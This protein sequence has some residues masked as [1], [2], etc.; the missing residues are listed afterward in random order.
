MNDKSKVKQLSRRLEDKDFDDHIRNLNKDRVKKCRE[1]KKAALEDKENST[2]TEVNNE[3]VTPENNQSV[4]MQDVTAPTTSTPVN[5][6]STVFRSPSS[7]P[8]NR[9]SLNFLPQSSTSV[10]PHPVA[11]DSSPS[12]GDTSVRFK[13]PFAKQNGDKQRRET[14]RNKNNT[15]EQLESQMDTLVKEND[16]LEEDNI[17]L[18]LESC[19]Q[20]KTIRNLED[21]KKDKFSWF[22]SMWKFCS[23]DTKREIKAAI[24]AAKDEFPTG[25]IKALRD[26]T[27]INFSNPLTVSNQLRNTG[28]LHQQI[29]DFANM[30]SFEVP[31]KKH[32]KKSI[33][34]MSHFK[35]VLHQQFLMENPEIDCHY[36]TFC[37]HFPDN[38]LKPGVNSHG[39]CLCEDCE[40]FSLK[41]EAMKRAKLVSDINLDQIIRSGR[42]GDIQ[43]EQDFLSVLSELKNSD[44]KDSVIS[45]FKWEDNKQVT[46]G[47]NGVTTTTKKMTR[48]NFQVTVSTLIDK[49]VESFEPLKQ[50]LHRDKVIKNF[51]REVRGEVQNDSSMVC[52]TVDLSENGTLIIPGEVQTAFFG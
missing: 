4:N 35:V 12:A 42:D 37:T 28:D 20:K 14:L 18:V 25:V 36:S 22:K 16:K 24:Q 15:I 6:T 7:T 21:E 33:R 3:S 26:N 31:D 17:S 51:I 34:Y 44:K 1:R 8:I 23:Q 46:H 38:I 45:Y 2:P 13:F 9:I 10:T 11:T 29:V 52:I 30:N 48:K 41:L 50:H 47:E 19:E 32:A 40:N 27:G 5:N 49:I 39:T 43:P